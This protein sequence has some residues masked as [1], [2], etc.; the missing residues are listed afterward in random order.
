[1]TPRSRQ[2]SRE[3][4]VTVSWPSPVLSKTPGG[5]TRSTPAWGMPTPAH[6][7]AKGALMLS[8]RGALL[9]SLFTGRERCLLHCC[10]V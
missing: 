2:R 8:I 1:M 6:A 3:Y 9:A 5:A 10:K 7:S 4:P